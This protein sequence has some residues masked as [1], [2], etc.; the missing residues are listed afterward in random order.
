MDSP[1]KRTSKWYQS[2]HELIQSEKDYIDDLEILRKVFLLPI[3]QWGWAS[4]EERRHCS[5][6]IFSNVEDLCAVHKEF[7]HELAI[8][9]DNADGSTPIGQVLRRAFQSMHGYKVYCKNAVMAPRILDRYMEKY[10]LLRGLV[11]E[12][13]E[14]P[15][16]RRLP[17]KSFLDRP[18]SRIAHY[19][20]FV[21]NLLKHS[22]EDQVHEL[23]EA[24][25]VLDQLLWEIDFESGKATRLA[26]LQRVLDNL[27]IEDRG[28]VI[29]KILGQEQEVFLI[30]NAEMGTSNGSMSPM[31]L[32]L[33]RHFVLIARPTHHFK[34]GSDL[35]PMLFE[36]VS[37]Q[38]VFL[39][40]I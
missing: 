5:S 29:R 25:H 13:T 27:V 9:A 17:I 8:L 11:C 32:I 40:R 10:P 38:S 28:D 2:I 37:D 26:N 34:D 36:E 7:Y 15:I 6:Q 22:R 18:R 16:C 21:N 14:I 30:D 24:K 19:G 1:E 23:K 4:E 20:L 31:I 12:L 33:L 39:R 3:L 35:V